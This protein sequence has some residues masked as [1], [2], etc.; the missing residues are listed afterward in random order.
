[1]LIDVD[2]PGGKRVDAH[3]GRYVVHTDQPRGAGGDGSAPSP[4]SLFLASLATCAGYYV[5]SFCQQ[6]GID[7]DGLRLVQEHVADP[8]TGHTERVRLEIILPPGFPVKYQAAV[9]RAAEQCAVKKLLDHPPVFEI[10]A[11]VGSA[12]PA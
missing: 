6:R 8:V 10:E 12:T 5:L 7:T 4:F 9:I 1:M 11:E 2:F 3:F